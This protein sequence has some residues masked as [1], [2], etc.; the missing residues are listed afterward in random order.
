[1]CSYNEISRIMRRLQTPILNLVDMFQSTQVSIVNCLLKSVK[2]CLAYVNQ[3][4]SVIV[5]LY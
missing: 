2:L 1:M 4:N 3:L 5:G